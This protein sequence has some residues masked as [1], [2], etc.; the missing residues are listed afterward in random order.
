MNPGP[1][2]KFSCGTCSKDVKEF[3]DCIC[4]DNCNILFHKSCLDLSLA[5]FDRYCLNKSYLDMSFMQFPII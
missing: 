1:I 3:T 2:V 4:C 5:T